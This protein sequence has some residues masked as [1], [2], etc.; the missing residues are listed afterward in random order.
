[1][2]NEH[3]QQMK[4][5]FPLEIR[6]PA[7]PSVQNW[8]K[9][10]VVAVVVVVLGNVCPSASIIREAH[11]WPH[12]YSAAAQTPNTQPKSLRIIFNHKKDRKS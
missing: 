7:V 4:N 9:A 12:I 8:Q 1:M 10:V 11:D 5:L 2:V 3:L 6:C